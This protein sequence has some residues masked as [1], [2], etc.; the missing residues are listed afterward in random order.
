MDLSLFCQNNLLYTQEKLSKHKPGGYHPVTL[1]DTFKNGLYETHYKLGYG[2]FSTVWLAKDKDQ[3]QWVSLKVMI[4]DSSKSNELQ[5]LKFLEKH[6]GGNLSSNH[7]VQLLDDFT[8]DGPNGALQCLVFELL[9]PTLDMV[10][11]EYS[12]G[13]DKL[14]PEDILRMSMQLL[15]AIKFIHSIGMCHGDI[16]GRNIAFPC[17]N[18]LNHEKDVLD[19]LGLLEI[20]SLAYIDGSPLDNGLPTQLVKAAEWIDFIDEDEEDIRLIDMGESFLPGEEPEKSAQPSILRIPET[21]FTD[22]FDY[23]L[24]LWRAGC[25]IYAFLF[26][27]Y[28]FRYFDRDEYL[29]FQMIDFVERLPIE[30]EPQWK[31]IQTKISRN[32]EINEGY[33]TSKFE[34]MFAENVHD[35]ELQP[36]LQ[37]VQGLMRF[38]PSNRIT[39]EEALELLYSKMQETGTTTA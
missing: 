31:T 1:G 29:I 34:R 21:I 16:S 24:D 11:T 9:G 18:M 17:N 4:A 5:N 8:H 36:L 32:L 25:I 30:W 23:R 2:G 27:N 28:P 39:A 33:E 26:T 12:E 6:S 20:E 13:N 38:L 10:L 19:V 22:R 37:V 3:N 14:N 7:I 15:K 35:P